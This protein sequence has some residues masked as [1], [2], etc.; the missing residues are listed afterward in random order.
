VNS[1]SCG[2]LRVAAPPF[3]DGHVDQDRRRARALR[4]RVLEEK[5]TPE[6]TEK[7]DLE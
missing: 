3:F 1:R 6:K 4:R 2:S 7:K 5:T